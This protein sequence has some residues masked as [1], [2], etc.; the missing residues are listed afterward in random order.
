MSPPVFF[1]VKLIRPIFLI[2]LLIIEC[3]PFDGMWIEIVI[4]MDCIDIIV[5]H[6]FKETI[7]N[8]FA[9]IGVT[10]IIV[11]LS[12]V[13]DDPLRMF[14]CGMTFYKIPCIR[15]VIGYTIRVHPSMKFHIPCMCFLNSKR[16][17]E[18]T[19]ELQSR[20]ELICR[21]PLE[22]HK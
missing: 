17:E 9:R 18:H 10:W 7:D 19:S 8:V 6:D 21:L 20:F 2:R 4:H 13:F 12:T 15:R 5:F 3:L 16:S 14:T 22:K 1:V 11:E